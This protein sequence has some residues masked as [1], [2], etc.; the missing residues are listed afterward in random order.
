MNRR[1]QL[2]ILGVALVV[3]CLSIIGVEA[4]SSNNYKVILEIEYFQ[5][6]HP[7]FCG[8]ATIQMAI[9]TVLGETPSQWRL[10]EE[11]P[12]VEDVGT[13]N[14]H[15]NLPF[16]KRDITIIRNNILGNQAQLRSSIEKGQVSIINIKFDEEMDSGHFVLVTG[17]NATGFFIH[18]PW[19][20][21]FGE[22]EGRETGANVY[23]DNQQLNRLW[24]FRLFW[25]L[26]VANQTP[27]N[28]ILATSVEAI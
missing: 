1:K 22:L 18:D 13:C 3:V 20:E 25:V 8:Q 12:F 9:N 5:Q 11:M 2:S 10:M 4:D 26:T 6:I 21:D 19:T 17:Y 16:K 15:M 28:L 23:I 24:A 27:N 14:K 7:Y